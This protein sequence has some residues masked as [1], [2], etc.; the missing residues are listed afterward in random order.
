LR[1]EWVFVVLFVFVIATRFDGI[2]AQLPDVYNEDEILFI[3]GFV[4]Q[5]GG[6]QSWLA[7]PMRID[8]YPPFSS[9]LTRGALSIY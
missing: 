6:I 9:Y 3:R 7:D 4:P 8:S 1:A 5:T 2:G